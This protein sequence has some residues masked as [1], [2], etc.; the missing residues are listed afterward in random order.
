MSENGNKPTIV[1]IDDE[2]MVV[3]SIKAFLE[4]DAEFDV[5]TFT[6]PVES[7][8]FFE[9]HQVDVAVSDYRMPRMNGLQLL[10]H[11]KEIQ[12][13]SSRVLLTS[14]G[15]AN[16]AIEAINQ[17]SLFQYLEK[18]WDNEQLLLVVR[19]GIERSK[20]LRDLREKVDELD[21]AH[22]SLKNAQKRL[23]HAFL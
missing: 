21:S 14:H 1:V 5:H 4:L 20:L 3:T 19:S 16:S 10:K 18:P 23:I 2:Q 15:D 17:V 12:P 11:L 9:S 8:K 6:D 13:E 7:V 22:T